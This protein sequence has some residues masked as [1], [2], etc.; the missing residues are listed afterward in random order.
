MR[1][2]YS[3]SVSLVS[4]TCDICINFQYCPTHARTD[5]AI[6]IYNFYTRDYPGFVGG[7]RVTY[8]ALTVDT[9]SKLTPAVHLV[10]G[11]PIVSRALWVQYLG[12]PFHDLLARRLDGHTG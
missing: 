5:S 4:F 8:T 11:G 10:V 1:V 6:M 2:S 12:N 7:Y 3:S 9:T